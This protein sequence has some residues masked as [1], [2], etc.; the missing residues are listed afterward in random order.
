MAAG[1]GVFVGLLGTIAFL[2]A[3]LPLAARIVSSDSAFGL[4]SADTDGDSL[5]W[6]LA[7]GAIGRDLL[8]IAVANLMITVVALVYWGEEAVQSALVVAVIVISLCGAVLALVHGLM[9]ARAL[10]KAK[11]AFPPGYRRY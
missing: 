9:T 1:L 11:Q 3:G 5:I 8:R 10:G 7:N 2:V 4:R 6:H